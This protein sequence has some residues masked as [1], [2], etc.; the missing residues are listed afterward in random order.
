MQ[1]SA[2]SVEL[3]RLRIRQQGWIEIPSSGTS[4]YPLITEGNLCRF[5]P[6]IPGQIKEGDIILFSTAQGRLLGHRVF[7]MSRQNGQFEYLCKG[8]TNRFPDDPV[9]ETQIVG[10][11]FIVR[12]RWCSL[13]TDGFIGRFWTK[14]MVLFPTGGLWIRWCLNRRSTLLTKIRGSMRHFP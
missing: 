13:R 6:A 9:T 1:Y 8:D 2:D 11:L 7:K 5:H 4:M 12:K 3:L 10:R 14:L